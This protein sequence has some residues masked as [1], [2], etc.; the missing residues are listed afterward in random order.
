VSQNQAPRHPKHTCMQASR[1]CR[2]SSASC[3]AWAVTTASTATYIACE[4]DI[5]TLC[6]DVCDACAGAACGGAVLRCLT[7]K[8]VRIKKSACKKEVF[9]FLKMEARA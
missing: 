1:G 4:A 6:G 2:R 8:K 7:E 3:A 5:P 9:C